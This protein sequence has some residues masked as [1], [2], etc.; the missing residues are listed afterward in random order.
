MN[1]FSHAADISPQVRNLYS[2]L[3][4]RPGLFLGNS[5]ESLTLLETYLRGL[6]GI[7]LMEQTPS[8]YVFLPDGFLAYVIA[9]Y[10]RKEDARNYASII[11]QEEA[12]ERAAFLKF[13]E[14][15]D[16]YLVSLGYAPIA[17]LPRKTEFSHEDGICMAYFTDMD[18]LAK[19][20]MQTFNAPPWNDQ[21]TEKAACDR[22]Y[23]LYRMPGFLGMVF[24]EHQMPVGAVL[25]R[26]E[27][28]YDGEYFQLIECWIQPHLQG[29]GYGTQL[30]QRLEEI[31]QARSIKKIYLI[32]MHSTAAA[33]FYQRCGFSCED[34]QCIM[35]KIL[36]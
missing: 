26:T 35:Q 8:E 10:H 17:Y 32:T 36:P 6:M 20:Y 34:S 4:T 19:S 23:E 16:A 25:G 12:G 5:G 31:L 3:R 1:Q 29:K 18:K 33:A 22:M 27:R 24:W 7:S 30:M 2:Q 9:H 11:R 13:W 21:W 28:Y 14:L 15:L